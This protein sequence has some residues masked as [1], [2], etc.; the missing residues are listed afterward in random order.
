MKRQLHLVA[1]TAALLA[2]A[3]GGNAW[4]Q[5]YPR[6][7]IRI[8]VPFPPGQ[9]SDV[10]VRL[11]GHKLSDSLGQ[12]IVVDN[13]PGAGGN[14]GSDMG[15]KAAADGYT[16]TMATAALPISASVYSRLPFNPGKDFAPITLMTITPL[17]LV[18][19]PALP[20]RSVKELIALAR[21]RPGELNFASSGSG[22]SHHLSGEMLKTVAQ[23]N[24]VHVPYK[25]SAAAHLDLIGG[26]VALMF[27]NIVPVTQHI[28]TGKLRALAVTTPRRSPTL[29]DIPTI[30][31]AGLPDFEAVAWFGML[32]PAGTPRDIVNRLNSEIVKVLNMPDVRDKLIGMGAE[33]VGS[34]PEQ[35][36]AHIQKEIA[37]WA[38]IVKIS[39]AVV[40]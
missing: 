7:S 35:F 24:I 15:A 27:D 28:R 39:G 40:D 30:I 9:A 5:S 11:V 2:A 3:C 19:N 31:E 38:R 20:V 13:R 29:P 4:S 18:V 22:T 21:A 32:A 14:I 12:P 6:K 26:Q 16:L 1:L 33:P 37:K 23:I 25:G 34:T 8:I 10:I 17:V 36:D